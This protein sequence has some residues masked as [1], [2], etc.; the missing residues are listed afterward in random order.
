MR[1][2]VQRPIHHPWAA[3]PIDGDVSGLGDPI[4]GFEVFIRKWTG[5]RV[6]VRGT[7]RRRA[8]EVA[9][10]EARLRKRKVFVRNPLTGN[11]VVFRPDDGVSRSGD[12][13]KRERRV[14]SSRP[15][16]LHMVEGAPRSGFEVFIRK[17]TGEEVL[18]YGASRPRAEE[19][20]KLEA[21]LQKRVVYVRDAVKGDTVAFRPDRDSQGER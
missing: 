8:E 15:A 17:W 16:R 19:F 6:I 13:G 11:T 18:L 1:P 12:S 3:G 9:R 21:R 10:S 5:E 2:R 14:R 4:S 20:A 7:S